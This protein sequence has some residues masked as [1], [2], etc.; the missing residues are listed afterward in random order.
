MYADSFEFN[1]IKSSDIGYYIMNFDGFSND[2]VGTAGNEITFTTSKPP[3]T[4]RWNFHGSKYENPLTASFQIGKFDCQKNR[5]RNYELSQ[6][7]CA[8]LIRWLVRSDGYKL[9]RFLLDGYKEYEH[10]YFR[11]QNTLQWIRNSGM[12]VG[13][14][15]D[16]TCDAPFGYS[17]MQVFETSCSNGGSFTIYDD[18]DRPG[19]LYFDEI[20][21]VM[22]SDAANLQ[23]QNSLDALYSPTIQYTTQIKNCKNGEHITIAS[24]MISTSKNTSHTRENINNDFNFKYPRLINFSETNETRKNTYTVSGGSCRLS[25]SYRTIRS[26]LP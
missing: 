3:N 15:L 16:I 26:V 7:D 6:Q 20:D 13:A 25:F 11:T 9:L 14:Q 12:I 17:D 1:G 19:A 22:A 24:H 4:S 21:I 10:T 8:F 23:I 18:S 2:G 5:D